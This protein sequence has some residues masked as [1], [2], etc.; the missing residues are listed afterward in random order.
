MSYFGQYCYSHSFGSHI[1]DLKVQGIHLVCF[2]I[3]YALC[4]KFLVSGQFYLKRV[5]VS[6]LCK[7]IVKCLCDSF[8]PIKVVSYILFAFGKVLSFFNMN[9]CSFRCVEQYYRNKLKP[10]LTVTSVCS[11]EDSAS[12]PNHE[13]KPEQKNGMTALSFPLF[14]LLVLRNS[15]RCY[16]IFASVSD[17]VCLNF[18]LQS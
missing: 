5:L 6:L 7:I 15:L 9:N 10:I 18:I 3:S 16:K 2:D 13:R 8:S 14:V 11:K 4:W 17:L 1:A 12:K